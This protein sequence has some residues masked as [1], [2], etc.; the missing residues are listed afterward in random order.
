MAE[1]SVL[2]FEYVA[3]TLFVSILQNR[4]RETVAN[5]QQ[6]LVEI[7]TRL[8][9]GESTGDPALDF[10]Y[11]QDGE[12][13]LTVAEFYMATKEKIRDKTGRLVVISVQTRGAYDDS[14]D[15]HIV[16]HGITE[17]YAGVLT[18]DQIEIRRDAGVCILHTVNHLRY[19]QHYQNVYMGPIWIHPPRSHPHTIAGVELFVDDEVQ[20]LY[21]SYPQFRN[22]VLER[23]KSDI[24]QQMPILP[25]PELELR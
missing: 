12:P 4:L 23:K 20:N 2:N 14:H 6:L 19:R 8:R 25:V 21:K 22:F 11:I 24:E 9:G 3:K 7:R 15:S 1:L 16:D 10:M 5:K 18:S 17:V 13:D